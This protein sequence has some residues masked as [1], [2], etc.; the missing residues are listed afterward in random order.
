MGYMTD[1]ASVQCGE[2]GSPEGYQST[3]F[4]KNVYLVTD[5]H[6]PKLQKS[7][8][9]KKSKNNSSQQ[10]YQ[11][12]RPGFDWLKRLKKRTFVNTVMKLMVSLKRDNFLIA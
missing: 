4:G 5:I 1:C 7:E 9:I 10:C 8:N 6:K 11:H 3:H 2:L 12:I